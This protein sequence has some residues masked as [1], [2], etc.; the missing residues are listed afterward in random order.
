MSERKAHAILLTMRTRN[1]T[2]TSK[3]QITLPADLVRKY[4]LDENRVMEVREKPG[5]VLELRPAPL[6]EQIMKKHWDHFKKMNP[7]YI[8]PTG[9]ELDDMMHDEVH[10]TYADHF[11]EHGD[12]WYT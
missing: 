9:K 6:L 10:D 11:K 5:G 7:D 4:K 12:K 3:N 1:V 2:V 8:P